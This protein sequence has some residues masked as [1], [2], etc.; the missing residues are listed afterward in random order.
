MLGYQVMRRNRLLSIITSGPMNRRWG[1]R[2]AAC[3]IYVG[4]WADRRTT[5]GAPSG[6]GGSIVIGVGPTQTVRPNMSESRI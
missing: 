4:G 2:C 6:L 5:T 3:S 1:R